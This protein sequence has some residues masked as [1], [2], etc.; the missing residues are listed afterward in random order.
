MTSPTSAVDRLRSAGDA[1]LALR[2]A[3]EAGAP[4]PLASHF[5]VEPEAAWGPPEVLAHV[6]EMLGFWLGEIERILDGPIEPVAFGRVETDAVRLGL[7]ER[8]RSLPPRELFA[9]IGVAIHRLEGR[10]PQ[11]TEADL[12]RRGIRP[13][14]DVETVGGV[15]DGFLIGHLEAHVAQLRESLGGPAS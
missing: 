6:A 3:V 5:G 12:A 11:L 8:D 15:V 4:W 1:F 7:I 14:G 9:R 2:P 10:L 13:N